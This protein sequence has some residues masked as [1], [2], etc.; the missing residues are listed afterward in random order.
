MPRNLRRKVLDEGERDGGSWHYCRGLL[1][2]RRGEIAVK[3]SQKYDFYDHARKDMLY[4]YN[5]ME[6]NRPRAP[7]FATNIAKT[8]RKLGQKKNEMRFLNNAL[9]LFP[10]Y[11]DLYTEY[12]LLYYFDNDFKNAKEKLLKANEL[13]NGKSSE[14]IYF[15][16]LTSLEAGSIAEAKKYAKQ[17]ND[18]GYPL[19]GLSERIARYEQNKE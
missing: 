1:N 16:G 19:K 14:V 15:L 10:D 8:Y 18:M 12:G 7:V 3:P 9:K 4:S 5:S 11:A 2:Y 6:K 13:H 17:A